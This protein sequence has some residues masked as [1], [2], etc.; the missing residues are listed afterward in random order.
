MRSSDE[1]THG[2]IF[3][4]LERRLGLFRLEGGLLF[5]VYVFLKTL[6]IGGYTLTKL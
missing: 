6:H 4:H 3:R 2:V 1:I 5:I